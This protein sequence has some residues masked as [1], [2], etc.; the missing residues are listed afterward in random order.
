MTTIGQGALG[1]PISTIVAG[2]DP[3]IPRGFE[4]L[5]QPDEQ[6]LAL[7][8]IE[9]GSAAWASRRFHGGVPW[10]LPESREELQL[11]SK[12]AEL[13]AEAGTLRRKLAD[14]SVDARAR[15]ATITTLEAKLKE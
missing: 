9:A 1:K 4:Y 8:T 11:E 2:A 13:A 10:V 15:E 14:T 3:T 6:T 5:V 7:G 12:V